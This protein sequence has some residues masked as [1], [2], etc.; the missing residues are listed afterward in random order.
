MR[1]FRGFERGPVNGR[2]RFWWDD[3]DSRCTLERHV[4]GCMYVP[5]LSPF[6]FSFSILVVVFFVCVVCVRSHRLRSTPRL[7][8]RLYLPRSRSPFPCISLASFVPL[9]LH[10]IHS[11]PLVL[12]FTSAFISF[13]SFVSRIPYLYSIP[14]FHIPYCALRTSHFARHL[15]TAY[16]SLLPFPLL[17][18]LSS[19]HTP[20]STY[21][22]IPRRRPHLVSTVRVRVR[23]RSRSRVR[24]VRA[25]GF[26]HTRKPCV[27]CGVHR[28]IRGVGCGI[29]DMGY[30]M[31]DMGY[32]V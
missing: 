26:Q 30:G 25:A 22:S 10:S 8:P 23:V 28:G 4:P 6:S 1:V 24:A 21:P 29:W 5:R 7:P 11:S 3:D 20:A 9:R 31:S 18:Y 13:L 19:F 16:R 12:V 14:V 2:V 17:A 27:S 32:G 15:H